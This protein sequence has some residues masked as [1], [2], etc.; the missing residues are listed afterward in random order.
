MESNTSLEHYGDEHRRLVE[1][2]A[3]VSCGSSRRRT[4]QLT[5]AE[6]A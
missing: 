5:H 1:R 6:I 4:I 2:L 3:E